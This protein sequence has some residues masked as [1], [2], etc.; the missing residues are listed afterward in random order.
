MVYEIPLPH[1]PARVS[2]LQVAA[3]AAATL[4]EVIAAARDEGGLTLRQMRAVT[5]GAETASQ[6]II[7]VGC[8]QPGA[9]QVERWPRADLA[10]QALRQATLVLDDGRNT[11]PTPNTAV[12]QVVVLCQAGLRHVLGPSPLDAPGVRPHEDHREMLDHLHKIANLLP[13]IADQLVEI[14]RGWAKA[15]A[16][17]GGGDGLRSGKTPQESTPTPIDAQAE[18]SGSNL[19]K[20]LSITEDART[21]AIALAEAMHRATGETSELD[22]RR[23]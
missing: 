18:W 19:A 10:W 9:D 13:V 21:Q 23:A 4:V 15:G 6:Y 22:R 14:I 2:G 16:L 12:G 11:V 3:E 8:A 5:V 7:G 17:A 1:L 20:L